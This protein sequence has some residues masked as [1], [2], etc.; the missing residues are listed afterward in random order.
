[1]AAGMR[2]NCGEDVRF[3]ELDVLM[4]ARNSAH[5]C[6]FFDLAPP[7]TSSL[8]VQSFALRGCPLLWSR[9]ALFLFLLIQLSHPPQSPT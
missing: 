6:L 1:M 8:A 2:K 5:R 3:P 4:P 9:I 7:T